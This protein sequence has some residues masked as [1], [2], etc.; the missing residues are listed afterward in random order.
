MKYFVCAKPKLSIDLMQ[1]LSFL[2]HLCLSLWT[3]IWQTAALNNSIPMSPVLQ[4]CSL[5]SFSSYPS[6][7]IK[8]QYFHLTRLELSLWKWLREVGYPFFIKSMQLSFIFKDNNNRYCRLL[9]PYSPGQVS[10]IWLLPGNPVPSS[11]GG[12]KGLTRIVVVEWK[13][14][15]TPQAKSTK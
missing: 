7:E 11:M 6:K 14:S 8:E 12:G 10:N 4:Q 2:S 15:T 9:L 3:T 5:G 13:P 1:S